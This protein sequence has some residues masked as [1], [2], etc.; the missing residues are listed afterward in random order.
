MREAGMQAQDSAAEQRQI[1]R[2]LAAVRETIVQVPFCWVV[3]PAPNG[4]D[5]HARIVKAQPGGAGEDFWTRWF[6]TP[7]V[8]RKA[9]EMR[10]TGRVTLA[11]QHD[12]GNAYVALSGVLEL[13]DNRIEVESPFFPSATVYR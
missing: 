10:T 11:Y 3:T 6:L 9:A 1:D 12:S 4:R 5:A 13:T 8:G 7:R 2:L